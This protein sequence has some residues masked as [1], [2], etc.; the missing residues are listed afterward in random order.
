MNPISIPLL[1]I[2]IMILLNQMINRKF[3]EANFRILYKH[4]NINPK[5]LVSPLAIELIKTGENIKALK[6]IRKD[7]GFGLKESKDILMRVKVEI[8]KS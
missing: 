2:L 1:L 6:Q 8:I 3:I 7:T 4:L 5:D